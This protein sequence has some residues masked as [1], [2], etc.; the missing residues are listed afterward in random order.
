[1][2]AL[3][4]C[5]GQVGRPALGRIGIGFGG[6]VDYARGVILTS[7][8]VSQWDGYPLRQKLAAQ[9]GAAVRLDNDAN[10]G[11]LGEAMYGAG[12]GHANLVYVNVGTGIG[13]GLVLDGRIYRGANGLAGELGHVTV[14]D[15]PAARPCACGKRGCLEVYAS[16]RAIGGPEVARRAQA[17]DEGAQSRLRDAALALARALGASTNL[18]NP[19]AIVVGGGVAEAGELLLG[20]L[21]AAL[22]REL[23]P[24]MPA[25]A[26]SPA[27]LEYDAGVIGALALA[28]ADSSAD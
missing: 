6:P 19:S 4:E 13:A 17:G 24:G 8:H 15:G 10:V 25:P 27:A 7:H 20:P 18:L 2:A 3:E 16:G 9:F 22:A 21:R 23:M 28:S 26:V 11:A 1:M 5:L 12:R 14:D